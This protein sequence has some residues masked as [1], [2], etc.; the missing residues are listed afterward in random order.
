MLHLEPKNWLSETYVVRESA[1][2]ITEVHIRWFKE[3]GAFTLE[4]E[5][6]RIGREGMMSGEFFIKG[7]RA[8]IATATKPS[9]FTRHFVV[10]ID[11]KT[12]SLRGKSLFGR[13]YELRRGRELVGTVAPQ[14]WLSRKAQ[15]D[16]PE[17]MP[18]ETQVFITWLVLVMWKRSRSASSS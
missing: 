14:S 2:R 12:Y 13:T 18:I 1:R 3:A 8:T 9:A 6:Y 15:A 4:G 5:R 10:R 17:D 7:P 11:G 16:L